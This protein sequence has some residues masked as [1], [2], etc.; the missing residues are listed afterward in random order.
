MGFESI[1]PKVQQSTSINPTSAG[2]GGY[3]PIDFS[4]AGPGKKSQELLDKLDSSGQL[5]QFSSPTVDGDPFSVDEDFSMPAANETPVSAASSTMEMKVTIRQEP[6]VGDGPNE[7]IFKVMP[8]VDESGGA[9]YESI[10]PVQH[11][12]AIQK[13]R[14]STPRTWSVSG[15]LV[16]RTVQEATENVQLLNMIRSW[17]MPFYGEGTNSS[18]GQYLG[19][20]PPILTLTA[21]GPTVIGP[22][23]CVL[24]NYTWTFDNLI[25]YIP[26]ENG[27]AFPVL[28]DVQ[29]QLTE[30][31]S[32][33]EFS[34]F[35]IVEYKK[36]NLADFGAF[37]RSFQPTPQTQTA[38][39]MSRNE[40]TIENPGGR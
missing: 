25:D 26:T 33:A 29:L 17:R 8:R 31:W 5:D 19:A 16:S 23:K 10:I 39:N 20:P 2:I 37:T 21:Y 3:D 14:S 27:E 32:P 13:F 11:P 35:N 18:M 34:S 38:D 28:L 40:P 30:S 24:T 6:Q 1:L 15:R 22:V 7:I 9:D 4:Q 36:G 12:G